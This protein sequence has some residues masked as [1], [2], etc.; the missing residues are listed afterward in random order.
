MYSIAIPNQEIGQVVYVRFGFL[1]IPPP[2]PSIAL[3]LNPFLSRVSSRPL[4]TGP[5]DCFSISRTKRTRHESRALKRAHAKANTEQK[6]IAFFKNLLSR[7]LYG[8]PLT[9]HPSHSKNMGTH[10]R[11]TTHMYVPMY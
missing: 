3:S 11:S 10:T 8:S 6:S 2:S 1:S 4:Q 9:L 7:S 5:L